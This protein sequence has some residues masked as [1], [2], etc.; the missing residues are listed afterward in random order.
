[1]A[2][3][4]KV[5]TDEKDSPLKSKK[6]D[7]D[8]SKEKLS[9]EQLLQQQTKN[10]IDEDDDFEEF[11]SL[12]VDEK[13]LKEFEDGWQDAGWDDDDVEEDFQQRLKQEILK[14]G[15]GK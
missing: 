5:P 3:S 4:T 9:K 11:G 1:M 10:L 15:G 8:P 14:F 12:K 13:L 2:P 6:A 7:N